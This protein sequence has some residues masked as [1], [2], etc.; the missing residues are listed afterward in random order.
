VLYVRESGLFFRIIG[1]G[2][3]TFFWLISEH[4]F[5]GTVFFLQYCLLV[6]LTV[7]DVVTKV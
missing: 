7:C 5:C 4:N 2:I 6:L 1:V 3:K